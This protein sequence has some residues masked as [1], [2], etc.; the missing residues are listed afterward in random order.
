MTIGFDRV[1]GMKA[2]QFGAAAI[3]IGKGEN[4]GIIQ[5]KQLRIIRSN[6][7]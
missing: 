1:C 5:P 6:A 2:N 3:D 7:R 4:E